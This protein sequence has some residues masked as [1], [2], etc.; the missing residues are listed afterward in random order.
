MIFDDYKMAISRLKDGRNKNIVVL[1][2][3]GISVPSGIPDFRSPKGT[4]SK[5]PVSEYGSIDIFRRDPAKFWKLSYSLLQ[6][7]M[8]GV[9]PNEGHIALVELES[10]GYN[11]TIV[12]QNVDGLHSEAGSSN[13]IEMHGSIK[14]FMCPSCRIKMPVESVQVEEKYPICKICKKPIKLDIVF[15]GED[16]RGWNKAKRAVLNSD[17][18]IIVGTSGVV[19]PANQ[20]PVISESARKAVIFEFNTEI[21]TFAALTDYFF[22]GSSADTLPLFVS[23]LGR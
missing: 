7:D 23:Y 2:G 14:N 19:G 20:I 11:V 5:F 1:T 10:L 18:V 3:A 12:T 22:R 21:S 16:V 9:K 8:S 6:N 13:V 15:F 4:W 17:N